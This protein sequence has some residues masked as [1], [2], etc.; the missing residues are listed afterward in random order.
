MKKTTRSILD[1]FPMLEPYLLK[2]ASSPFS[3]E[4][5]VKL[6]D[7]E[8]TFLKLAWYFEDPSE[9]DFNLR[10]I[11]E[12]LSDD[13]LAFAL[14]KIMLFF[15]DDTY[16]LKEDKVSIVTDGDEYYINTTGNPGMATAGSGDVLTGII[17]SLLGQGYEDYLA[18]K[19]GVY[20]HGFAGD[21]AKVVY[22]EE[23]LL[24]SDLVKY[25]GKAMNLHK[26]ERTI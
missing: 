10:D 3:A 15:R 9:H 12:T 6:N 13:W 11:Y 5:I 16:L 4:D 23:G 14:E 25:I 18:A 1:T 20:F 24:A 19:L 17:T 26:K 7:I 8:Q 22:G 2:E 21:M